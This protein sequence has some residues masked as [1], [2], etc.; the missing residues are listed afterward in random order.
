MKLLFF[1]LNDV[2]KLDPLMVELADQGIK[3]ATVFTSTGM[4]HSLYNHGESKLMNSLRALLGPDQT[5]NKTILTVVNE[6]Q[7]KIFFDVTEK[8]VGDLN[9]PNT[10]VI[11]TVPVDN[12]RGLSR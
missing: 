3:G 9:K 5:E 8:I 2:S 1:V 12:V 6:E 4:A 10:G 11:F 7:E